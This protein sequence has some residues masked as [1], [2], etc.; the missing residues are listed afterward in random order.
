MEKET[1]QL[2]SQAQLYQQQIQTLITQK[3]ALSMEL[4]EI[5]KALEEIEKTK[6][7]SVLKVSGP[8]LIKVDTKDM[9]KDLGEKENMI[10]LRLKTIEKQEVK[11]KEKIEELRS[12]LTGS[13][14]KAG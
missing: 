14:P 10:N 13:E 8:I 5:K 12:K 2:L 3:T 9:K 7:K 11:V 1:E 4:N 6:E